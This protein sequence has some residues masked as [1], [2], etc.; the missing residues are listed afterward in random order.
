MSEVFSSISSELI[1]FYNSF[2]PTLPVFYQKFITLFFLSLVIVVYAV[3][4][5]KFYRFVAKKNIL[6]L[7]LKKYNKS[8]HQFFSKIIAM[9]FYFV[10]YIIIL[11]LVIFFWFAIFTFFLIVLTEELSINAILIV[12]ATIIAAIRMTAY[13]SEDLSKDVAKLLPL[14]LLAS[15]V[16]KSGFF[17]L[18]RILTQIAQIPESFSIITTY[19]GF[20]IILEII[21]RLFD[22]IFMVLGVADEE[23]KEK[24][25]E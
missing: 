10:E 17:D 19:L 11:P 12:S 4:I 2:F 8:E 23:E 7:N 3:F 21:L 14:T 18:K 9:V 20:I 24:Q 13:Y 22:F 1:S 25:E 6:D 15:A 16:T 5:W